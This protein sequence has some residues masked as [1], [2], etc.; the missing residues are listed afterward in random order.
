MY[1]DPTECTAEAIYIVACLYE[2]LKQQRDCEMFA[3]AFCAALRDE[4]FKGDVELEKATRK[5]EEQIRLPA[6]KR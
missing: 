5:T 6:L 2:A 1:G 4:V 3:D